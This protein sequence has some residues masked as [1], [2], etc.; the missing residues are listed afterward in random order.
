[1]L[2]WFKESLWALRKIPVLGI[3]ISEAIRWKYWGK[4]LLS[5]DIV[6]HNNET[7]HSH[8]GSWF[9]NTYIPLWEKPYQMLLFDSKCLSHSWYN[10]PNLCISHCYQM[11]FFLRSNVVY[12]TTV[13]NSNSGKMVVILRSILNLPKQTR[14]RKLKLHGKHLQKQKIDLFLL[15]FAM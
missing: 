6:G 13:K 4:K 7:S 9:P 2:H 14:I 15:C 12:D 1:M 5:V 8:L 10:N 3:K 11:T